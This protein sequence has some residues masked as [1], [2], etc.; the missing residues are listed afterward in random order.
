MSDR[1]DQSDLSGGDEDNLDYEPE[2]YEEYV[3]Q[4]HE[5]G[6]DDDDEEDYD[7]EEED[8]EEVERPKV[9][10]DN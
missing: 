4:G 1:S 5:S 7:P 8:E 10:K 3:D 6:E 2:A 9:V